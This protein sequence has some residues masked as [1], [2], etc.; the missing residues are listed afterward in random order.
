MQARAQVEVWLIDLDRHGTQ[1]AHAAEDGFSSADRRR[2][3]AFRDPADATAFAASRAG[4]RQLAGRWNAPADIRL[5]RRKAGKPFAPGLPGFSISHTR[6]H[7]AIA[8]NHGGTVGVDIESERAVPEHRLVRRVA[9]LLGARQTASGG[10]IAAWTV[11]EAWTKFHGLTLA[12]VLDSSTRVREVEAS[13]QAGAV[14][15]HLALLQLPAGCAGACWYDGPATPLKVNSLE[16]DGEG[17][18]SS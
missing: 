10:L 4:L 18:A 11:I 5:Q 12:E 1:F 8:I 6:R 13:L 9:E 17:D 16:P 15:F 14:G 7:V 3:A 2:M